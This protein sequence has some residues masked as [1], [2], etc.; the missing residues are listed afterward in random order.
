M[1]S[2]F[3]H[4]FLSGGYAR[5]VDQTHQLAHRNSLGNNGLSIGLFADVAGDKRATDVFGHGLALFNLHIGNHH[6]RAMLR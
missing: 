3:A 5:A 6:M 2:V 1:G 4:G